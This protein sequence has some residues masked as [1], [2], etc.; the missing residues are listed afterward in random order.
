[1]CVK[2]RSQK[3]LHIHIILKPYECIYDR[4]TYIIYLCVSIMVHIYTQLIYNVRA[5]NM[6]KRIH[7]ICILQTGNEFETLHLPTLTLSGKLTERGS[8]FRSLPSR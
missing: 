3:V 2:S 4:C 5:Y 8:V 7:S 6:E 1:M